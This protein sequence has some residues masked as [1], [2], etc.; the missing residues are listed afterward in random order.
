MHNRFKKLRDEYNEHLKDKNPKA[1]LYSVE[2][3]CSEMKNAG[4]KVSVSKIKKIESNQPG[5]RIDVDTLLAY[6][7][8][9]NVSADWLIDN[10]ISSKK[11]N[12]TVAS[13]A[14][15]TG[16]SDTS[17]QKIIKLNPEHKLILDKMISR[18]CLL[19]ILPE[20]RNLLGYNYLRP[21]LTLKFEEK[22]KFQN[23]AEIDQVLNN[24]INDNAVSSFF[25]EAINTILKAII[26]NTMNDEE[27]KK[28]FS[29]LDR[30]SKLST[31]PLPAEF[32]PKLS[33]IKE[34]D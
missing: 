30:N 2:D 29:E 14:Q 5:V 6:K 27:L 7:W 31:A 16:L 9:F 1:K 18:Y 13:A 12:G 4:F 10:T 8:K 3:M 23:G 11:L 26:D 32:L 28:N 15:T 21:H 25:N 19:L 22:R 33:D 24:A 34:S 17:I 20:I